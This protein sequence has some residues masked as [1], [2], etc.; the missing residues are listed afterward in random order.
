MKTLRPLTALPVTTMRT[1]LPATTIASGVTNQVRQEPLQNDAA[2][3][4]GLA[5]GETRLER[6]S[7]DEPVEIWLGMV[8]SASVVEEPLAATAARSSLRFR[9]V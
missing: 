4:N 2:W 9:D 3:R 7:I 8:D 1:G 5:E 6:L